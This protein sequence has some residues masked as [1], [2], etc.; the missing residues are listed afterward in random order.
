MRRS[1][2][3]ST[4]EKIAVALHR[5]GRTICFAVPLVLAMGCQRG[6]NNSIGAVHSFASGSAHAGSGPQRLTSEG[7]ARLRALLEAGV[8]SDLRWPGFQNYQTEVQEFY[9]SFNDTLPWLRDSEPTSQAVAIIRALQ[10]AETKGLRPEDY[11]GPKWDER[12]ETL[13]QSRPAPEPDLV[14]FD[15]ALTVSAMRYASD[16]H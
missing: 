6:F 4:A 15:V 3:L 11:D 13:Q 1:G 8:L 16:L 12:I 10:R 7:T 14:R 5:L 2:S 9:I